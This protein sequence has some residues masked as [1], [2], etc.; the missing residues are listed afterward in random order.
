MSSLPPIEGT[1]SA[2]PFRKTICAIPHGNASGSIAGP[3][4]GTVS[5]DSG[6]SAENAA[7][8]ELAGLISALGSLSAQAQ[9]LP[10]SPPSLPGLPQGQGY[11]PQTT[12]YTQFNDDSN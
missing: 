8:A 11:L 12:D 2:P 3:P 9:S 4:S 5:G 10:L 7:V 6:D 1:I